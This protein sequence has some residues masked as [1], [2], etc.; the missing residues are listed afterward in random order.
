MNQSMWNLLLTYIICVIW[1]ASF[2]EGY[3]IAYIKLADRKRNGLVFPFLSYHFRSKNYRG[4]INPIWK[5]DGRR[6]YKSSPMKSFCPSKKKCNLGGQLGDKFGEK[7]QIWTLKNKKT[8]NMGIIHSAWNKANYEQYLQM[9]CF[10]L[11][12]N[13]FPRRIYFPTQNLLSNAE[14]LTHW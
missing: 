12:K 7:R 13:T 4:L 5:R 8:E 1:K 9:I 6:I 2:F 3:L 11:Q 10:S 14:H